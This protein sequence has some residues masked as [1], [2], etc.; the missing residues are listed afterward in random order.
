M[1]ATLDR[2]GDIHDSLVQFHAELRR[3]PDSLKTLGAGHRTVSLGRQAA[4]AP[5]DRLL[6]AHWIGVWQRQQSLA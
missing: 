3:N 2:P 4:I 6:P 5:L 1:Y